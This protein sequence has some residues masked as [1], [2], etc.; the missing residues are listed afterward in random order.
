MF[1]V[2]FKKLPVLLILSNDSR[3]YTLV[4]SIP[5]LSVKTLSG[6]TI[7]KVKYG[8]YLLLSSWKSLLPKF[9][10]KFSYDLQNFM[11]CFHIIFQ[12]IWIN[13]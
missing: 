7:V 5:I 8:E 1:M 13:G 2:K 9:G 12:A 10:S 4:V 6:R 3:I 11:L